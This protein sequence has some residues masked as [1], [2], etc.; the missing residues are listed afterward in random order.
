MI[1]FIISAILTVL[2]FPIKLTLSGVQSRIKRNPKKS[3]LSKKHK[4][5]DKPK[6]I[7]KIK[8]KI[9]S[10]TPQWLKNAGGKALRLIKRALKFLIILIRIVII[11]ITI[12]EMLLII[13]AIFLIL[14]VIAAVAYFIL[15][16]QG[17]M[18]FAGSHSGSGMGNTAHTAQS[19]TDNS[20]NHQGNTTNSSYLQACQEMYDWY[21]DNAPYLSGDDPRYSTNPADQKQCELV[22]NAKVGFCCSWYVAAAL[23]K[24]GI[25][26][27][28][29]GKTCEVTGMNYPRKFYKATEAYLK[30]N[31]Q[32][33]TDSGD[34]DIDEGNTAIDDFEA[35]GFEAHSID[36]VKNGTYTLTAGDVVINDGHAEIYAGKNSDGIVTKWNWGHSY[37]RPNDSKN[38]KPGEDEV[39]KG[40]P[41]ITGY[42]DEAEYLSKG[43]LNYIWHYKG[44]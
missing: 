37:Y 42:K 34:T 32:K 28:S 18:S 19:N 6:K 4:D 29:E 31:K 43:S 25:L 12:F 5:K 13:G 36:E 33:V 40:S 14:T 22:D 7:G 16:N 17:I 20:Q 26:E 35:M 9:D 8:E 15:N 10:K 24:A 41:V 39:A 30:N 38:P 21:V 3:F 44:K 27:H 1:G 2:L 11:F 23:A